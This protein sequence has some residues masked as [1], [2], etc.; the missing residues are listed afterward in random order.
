MKSPE[1]EKDLAT[2]FGWA[3]LAGTILTALLLVAAGIAAYESPAVSKH[4]PKAA[5]AAPKGAERQAKPKVGVTTPFQLAEVDHGTDQFPDAV[6]SIYRTAVHRL[7]RS[8]KVKPGIN[9]ADLVLVTTMAMSQP[10][11][12]L[13]NP[14]SNLGVA[15]ALG[16]DQPVNPDRPCQELAQALVA[17]MAA[18]E[19]LE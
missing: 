10:P 1:R 3:L 14:K 15:V 8:C 16:S 4:T 6:L 7:E 12:S 2:L 18:A 5:P 11:V 19:L 17:T 9:H 13:R